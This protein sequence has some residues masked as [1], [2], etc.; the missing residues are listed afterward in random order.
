MRVSFFRWDDEL[1]WGRV[2]SV[3]PGREE[4]EE[5]APSGA[6]AVSSRGSGSFEALPT[7]ARVEESGRFA[8]TSRF[9]WAIESLSPG[10]A[11][12]EAGSS[13]FERLE[14][15][16]G[17]CERERE[18]EEPAGEEEAEELEVRLEA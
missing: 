14:R 12:L 9:S 8:L 4:E 10:R 6:R 1:G 15:E 18:P 5:A 3:P 13:D 11:E 17:E 16:R 2:P 7:P